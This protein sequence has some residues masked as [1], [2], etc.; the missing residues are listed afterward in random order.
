M[1]SAKHTLLILFYNCLLIRIKSKKEQD[2]M[3]FV[4]SEHLQGKM[5]FYGTFKLRVF[6]LFIVKCSFDSEITYLGNFF[7]INSFY[8]KN[9]IFSTRF[10]NA[11]SA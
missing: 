4:K 6:G 8:F 11:F 7:I 5:C 3:Q 2:L 10:W 1:K 9:K